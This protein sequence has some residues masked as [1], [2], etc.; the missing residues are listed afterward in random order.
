MYGFRMQSVTQSVIAVVA[1]LVTSDAFISA[2]YAAAE[3]MTLVQ[4]WQDCR[5]WRVDWGQREGCGGRTW[6]RH[7]TVY[8][9]AEHRHKTVYAP[10]DRATS[11]PTSESFDCD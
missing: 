4:Y 7:K 2:D 11:C 1:I 8:A 6:H 9:P 5:T 3:Q 10:A